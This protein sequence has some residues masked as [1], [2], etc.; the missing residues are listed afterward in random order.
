MTRTGLFAAVFLL[1]GV[2]HAQD[3]DELIRRGNDLR[4]KGQDEAALREFQRAY[5]LG[6]TPHAAASLGLAEQQLKRWGDAERHLSQ[7][8][9]DKT[10]PWVGKNR[11]VLEKQVKF[12]RGQIGRLE[13]IGDPAGAEVLVNNENVGTLPLADP[14]PVTPGSVRVEMR[15]AGY[16]NGA[17]SVAVA[18]GQLGHV[19]LRL[20]RDARAVAPPTFDAAKAAKT[21]AETPP[22][23]APEPSVVAEPELPAK[24]PEPPGPSA[25][26]QGARWVAVGAGGL[27]LAAGI[28]G[29]VINHSN[30][31]EVNSSSGPCRGVNDKGM[32]VNGNGMP[33][34]SC[35]SK[36]DTANTGKTV[37][38]VG[39]A[40]AG[41][42]ALTSAILFFAF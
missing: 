13:I 1:A 9:R 10:D 11:A 34:A 40:G 6:A 21:V 8:L 30:M 14:V 38:I 33:D 37:A 42:L 7:A 41:V 31:T 3:A 18:R 29:A 26:L 36:L 25:T 27:M 35:Q 22:T 4:R 32:A 20:E 23:A 16:L 19:D 2:A 24:Q 28:A 12:V 39:F 15:S 5:E 17:V